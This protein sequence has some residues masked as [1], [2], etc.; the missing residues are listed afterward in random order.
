MSSGGGSTLDHVRA[1]WAETLALRAVA[2]DDDFFELGGSSLVAA[3]AIGQL[4]AALGLDLP[5]RALFEAP[6]PAEMAELIAERLAE[7]AGSAASGLTGDVPAWL[8]PLQPTGSESPVFVFPA[9]HDEVRALVI[10]AQI[11]RA[12]GRDHPFWG[13]RREHLS[14]EQTREGGVRMLATAYAEHIRA[15]QPTGPVLLFGNCAGG[16]LAWETAHVLIAKGCEAVR[17][18]FFEVP[19]RDDFDQTLPGISSPFA[20]PEWRLSRDYRPEPLPLSLTHL[21]TDGWAANGWWKP[22]ERV[23]LQEYVPIVI[24]VA[25]IGVPAYLAQRQQIIAGHV[26]QWIARAEGSGA[27]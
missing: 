16:Y 20:P 23:V 3:A 24:P 22:W 17:T 4:N 2:P 14:L 11:A 5:V 12:V 27:G 10:D 13:L 6:T 25:E 7:G 21:M 9:G 26:R 18:L 15:L 19:L 1:A 8:V